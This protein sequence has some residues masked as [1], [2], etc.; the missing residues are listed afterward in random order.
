MWFVPNTTTAEMRREDSATPSSSTRSSAPSCAAWVTIEC[1]GWVTVHTQ[2]EY[3]AWID[4][5]TEL[6]ADS[7][8]DPFWD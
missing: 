2:E 3:D 7:G 4:E 8:G 1:S 5:E 6:L